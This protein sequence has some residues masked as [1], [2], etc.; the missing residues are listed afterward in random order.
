MFGFEIS[1]YTAFCSLVQLAVALNFGFIYLE[2][3]S[4]LFSLKE[5][6]F[7]T[8]KAG[9]SIIVDFSS[10]QLRRY[11]NNTDY[12]I[13]IENS[14]TK[15]KELHNIVTSPW[16]AEDELRFMPPLGVV[17]GLYSIFFLFLVCMFDAN[18]AYT[19]MSLYMT[20]SAVTIIC[21]V[22][23]IC[24]GDKYKH[25]ISILHTSYIYIICLG[26]CTFFVIQNWTLE[27]IVGFDSF[28]HY[29]LTIPFFPILYYILKISC[30]HIKKT[31]Y[32]SFLFLAAVDFKLLM[33]QR[34]G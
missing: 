16:D 29:S 32:A 30:C 18:D 12:T 34:A 15:L 4:L 22:V 25:R 10:K 19:Y 8:Y 17:F 5:K 28:F 9:N 31:Y 11:R 24:L 26:I 21:F 3:K 13:N 1:H 23:C 2:K 33:D 7:G 6:I 14:H 27:S 20:Y